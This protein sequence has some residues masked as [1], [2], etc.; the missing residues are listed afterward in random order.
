MHLYY[1]NQ[2]EYQMKIYLSLITS[3][4]VKLTFTKR[5]KGSGANYIQ[6]K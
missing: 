4:H 6:K 3:F 1:Q 5:L 2:E